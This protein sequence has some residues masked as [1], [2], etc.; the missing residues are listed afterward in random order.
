MPTD[1]PPSEFVF[2]TPTVGALGEFQ[3]PASMQA[4]SREGTIKRRNR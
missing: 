3:V 2:Q 1:G 4:M